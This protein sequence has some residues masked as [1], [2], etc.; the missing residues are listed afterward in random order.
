MSTSFSVVCYKSKTLKN[1]KNPLMLQVCKNGKRHYQSLGVS[2]NPKFWD[3]K[4]NKLKSNCPN[5][6][7]I[8]KIIDSMNCNCRMKEIPAILCYPLKILTPLSPIIS[9]ICKNCIFTAFVTASLS[10]FAA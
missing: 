6:E 8:Q 7:I 2:I 3:I 1:G 9:Q 5:K 4:K 10:A